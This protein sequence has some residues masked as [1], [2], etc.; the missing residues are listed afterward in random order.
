[1]EEGLLKAVI[2]SGPYGTAAILA[3]ALWRLNERK[4]EALKEVMYKLID[5]AK[6]QAT[7]MK[8]LEHTIDQALQ[9]LLDKQ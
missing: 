8:G 9:K 4:D 1:M 7:V 3:L 6:E 2:A 5:A